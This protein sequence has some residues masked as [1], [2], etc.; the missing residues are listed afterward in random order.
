MGR[1]SWQQKRWKKF[2]FSKH[3]SKFIKKSKS[4][5]MIVWGKFVVFSRII[6]LV[7]VAAHV[8]LSRE[9]TCDSSTIQSFFS[10][11]AASLSSIIAHTEGERELNY[12]SFDILDKIDFL[13]WNW[14]N[15]CETLNS[16]DD[17]SHSIKRGSVS[18]WL[19][20]SLSA[21]LL[22]FSNNFFMYILCYQIP[23]L[24]DSR[25][26]PFVIILAFFM[27]T[28]TIQCERF[29]S[30]FALPSKSQVVRPWRENL[31]HFLH[32][33]EVTKLC[34]SSNSSPCSVLSA[35]LQK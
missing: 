18:C 30:V 6:E 27:R 4:Y 8:E 20:H 24:R 16:S 35:T 22:T 28:F 2:H 29:G 14:D 5:V 31:L 17:N 25:V 15:N 23:R 10:W 12:G 32:D 9:S 1:R 33:Y 34:E 3:S 26:L 21:D 13:Y 19:V 11:A 7:G